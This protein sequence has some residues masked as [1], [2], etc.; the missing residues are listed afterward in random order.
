MKKLVSVFSLALVLVFVSACKKSDLS[1]QVSGAGSSYRE[2]SQLAVT[3]S[4]QEAYDLYRQAWELR[5]KSLEQES[6]PLMEKA[7]ALDPE[8]A[9]A[10]RSIAA[11]LSNIGG[12]ANVA[13]S[14]EYLKKAWEIAQSSKTITD[15]EEWMIEAQYFQNIERDFQ[16]TEEVLQKYV[17][18]Y[19]QDPD[20]HDYMGFFE[21][22]REDW[23]PA[24]KHLALAIEYG[25]TRFGIFDGLGYVYMAKGM[26]EDAREV[27]RNYIANVSDDARMRRQLANAYLY[28]GQ[29]DRALEEADKAMAMEPNLYNK[30][31]IYFLMGDLGAAESLYKSWLEMTN[32]GAIMNGHRYLEHLY[33]MQGKFQKAEQ[34]ALAGLTL[35]E[36]KNLVGWKRLFNNL[37]A[38]Y[39]F[40]S[41][42]LDSVLKK[43]EFN[44]E[45]YLKPEVPSGLVNA[46]W[47]K[48]RVLLERKDIEQALAYAEEAKTILQKTM[49]IKD[50]RWY[51]DDLG[52]IE[53]SRGNYPQ[54]IE[55]LKEVYNLQ[56]GQLDWLEP[57]GYILNNLA[58]AYLLNGDLDSAKAEYERILKLTT[59]RLANGNF[60]VLAFYQ[61]GKI[62]EKQGNVSGAVEHYEKFLELW[63][64][65][66]P[67]LPEVEDARKRLAALKG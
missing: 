61:L 41:G 42:D 22:N 26:Y 7:I 45:S 16:K 51:L 14:Q 11:S 62:H 56:G 3:T 17:S 33:R 66:D 2:G 9:M 36:E 35:A 47:W 27:F 64:D 43:A 50:D 55:H 37:S 49:S 1:S 8:F 13:K 54:A 65:A 12:A 34:E 18:K 46:L 59:G 38:H 6:I 30:S 67:G 29:Y 21:L 15:R 44:W 5:M 58:T 40:N 23:D 31:A 19:P 10:Y 53:M 4:S 48:I 39:D 57:H 28:E 52:L 63:K 32:V 25:A 60:Y 24:I 20:A